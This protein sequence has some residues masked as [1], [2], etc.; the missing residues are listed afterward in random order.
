MD[1]MPPLH[2][3]EHV[4]AALRQD[5]AAPLAPVLEHSLEAWLPYYRVLPCVLGGNLWLAPQDRERCF[6]LFAR[7]IL[8]GIAETV[9]CVL[10]LPWSRA[11]FSHTRLLK[12]FPHLCTAY[13]L[14]GEHQEVYAHLG[15]LQTQI[16]EHDCP[17]AGAEGRPEAM[18]HDT[19]HALLTQI[20]QYLRVVLRFLASNV[21]HYRV[22]NPTRSVQGVRQQ[23]K[24]TGDATQTRAGAAGGC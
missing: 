14:T 16:V 23:R 11:E 5:A 21:E 9:R 18:A 24:E 22:S 15:A 12:E 3:V 6:Y 10:G 17:Q 8:H 1:A 13:R 7:A 19:S 4:L 20:E 2:A